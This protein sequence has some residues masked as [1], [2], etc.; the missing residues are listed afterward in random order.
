MYICIQF[1]Q[2]YLCVIAWKA[3]PIQ[4]FPVGVTWKITSENHHVQVKG[5]EVRVRKLN[6]VLTYQ[7][8]LRRQNRSRSLSL[9]A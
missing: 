4:S 3:F 7:R 1:Q 2:M 8:R 5:N 6:D 9:T